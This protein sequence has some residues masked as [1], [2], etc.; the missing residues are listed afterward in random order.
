MTASIDNINT[1][2]SEGAPLTCLGAADAAT[3]QTFREKCTV[4]KTGTGSYAGLLHIGGGGETLFVKCYLAKHSIARL[5]GKLAL[6]RGYTA[7]AAMRALAGRL[8]VPAERGLVRNR[9]SGNIYLFSEHLAGTDL[10][11]LY[12]GGE[13]AE[14]VLRPLLCLAGESLARMHEAGWVHGDFKWGNLL[15][16]QVQPPRLALLDFDGAGRSRRAVRRGRDVARFIVNAEDYRVPEVLARVFLDA[17][18][19]AR[20]MS[21]AQVLSQAAPA[22]RKLR[23]RHDRKYG[24]REV[25]LFHGEH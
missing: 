25:E 14:P 8:R 4:L 3:E 6:G 21:A 17:Y 22:L 11:Q 16:E 1:A 2:A 15:V 20:P 5:A 9:R 23:A 12:R 24:L 19:A 10:A 18:A 13:L 7:R